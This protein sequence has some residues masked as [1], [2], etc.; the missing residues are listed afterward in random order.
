MML[1]TPPSS[2]PLKIA[3]IGT[4]VSGLAAAWLL[5]R[6]HQVTVFEKEDR[7]G[8]H[9]NTVEVTVPVAGRPTPLRVDTG[10]IVYNEPNYPNLTALFD[11]LG[12]E[13]QASDMSFA[14]SLDGGRLEYAG[15]GPG[16]V[17]QP[18]NLLRPRF[19]R[20]VRDL[21]RFY[22]EAPRLLDQPGDEG[23]TLGEYLTAGGYSDAFLQDHLLPM[24]AAIWSAPPETLRAYPAR[25][26]IRFC[27]NHGL[28]LLKD[29]PLWRTVVGG[30]QAYVGKLAQALGAGLRVN[31][32]VRQV[33]RMGDHVLVEDRQ[34]DVER[35]DH[36]VIATHSDQALALLADADAGER[37]A[38]SAIPYQRNLAI[39]HQD[40]G[41]M[42]RR[43]RVWSAWNFLR[44]QG[45]G[46]GQLCVTYW[47]NRLQHLTTDQPLLV[48]LNPP[49][50]PREGTILRSFLYDHPVFG[51]Q[52][53]AAQKD[54]WRVQ[55]LRR[56]WFCGAWFGAGFHEDG[57][58]AGL[59][60]AEALG[61]VRRPWSVAGE[62][63]R[64]SLPQGWGAAGP[65]V[66]A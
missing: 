55:G 10:F 49:R 35:F 8:G 66:A 38:L 28:L 53:V 16:M 31:A 57:L 58:Q 5:A 51:P 30:S 22:T 21:L 6:R 60:V 32:A 48:T 27:Q 50:P 43:R 62:S 39:L 12:V 45:A 41:L 2:D 15:S 44:P 61:G 63:A 13:T 64:L 47:M 3:V 7:P 52:S 9:A 46:D 40:P 11:H 37:A 24:A 25:S 20:M 36:V 4:G 56:T 18:L 33:R 54:I 34:G 59:A 26:F 42:P 23:L 1:P 19:H 14:A 29:R 17:A 65:E